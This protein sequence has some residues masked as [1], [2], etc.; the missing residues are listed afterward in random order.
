MLDE[1]SRFFVGMTKA[2]GG[3]A[4]NFVALTNDLM[5]L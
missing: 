4:A 1:R 3:E 5:K 2:E